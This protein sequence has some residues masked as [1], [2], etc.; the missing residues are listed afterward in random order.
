MCS[1][2]ERGD[3]SSGWV[4]TPTWETWTEVQAPGS[5]HCS[6]QSI[7]SLPLPFYCSNNFILFLKKEFR[8]FLQKKNSSFSRK[9]IL[10]KFL[11]HGREKEKIAISPATKKPCPKPNVSKIKASALQCP[12]IQTDTHQT[13]LSSFPVL[14]IYLNSK[15]K[16]LYF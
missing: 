3:S 11:C 15:G 4:L 16:D 9:V 12:K 14:R 8:T 6:Y 7:R 1:L 13:H 5:C 10:N 2:S